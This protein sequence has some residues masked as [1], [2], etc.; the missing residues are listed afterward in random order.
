[1]E[2]PKV[3]MKPVVR[4]TRLN[5]KLNTTGAALNVYSV[6]A[7]ESQNIIA[8]DVVNEIESENKISKEGRPNKVKRGRRRAIFSEAARKKTTAGSC[9]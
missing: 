4:V 9:S 1:M 3:L 5:G 8:I 7:D 2:D 6:N